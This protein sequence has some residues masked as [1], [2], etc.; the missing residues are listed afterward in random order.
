M[1]YGELTVVITAPSRREKGR[2]VGESAGQVLVLSC[3]EQFPQNDPCNHLEAL[4]AIPDLAIGRET[5]FWKL[6]SLGFDRW[7]YNQKHV[8][9]TNHPVKLNLQK[10]KRQGIN[11]LTSTSAF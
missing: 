1:C 10:L 11:R 6:T 9:L 2:F 5:S 7:V 8:L 3:G 4:P